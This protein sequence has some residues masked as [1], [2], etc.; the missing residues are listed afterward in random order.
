MEGQSGPI[1][2]LIKTFAENKAAERICGGQVW[3]LG[4]RRWVP[5]GPIPRVITITYTLQPLHRLNPSSQH[6]HHGDNK[7]NNLDLNS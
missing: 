5:S 7:C 2:T 3:A 4:A 1:R 6:R